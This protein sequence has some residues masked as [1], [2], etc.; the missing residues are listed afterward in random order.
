MN[1]EFCGYEYDEDCGKYGCP[2][3]NGEGLGEESETTPRKKAK[4]VDELLAEVRNRAP[5]YGALY[6]RKETS[7]DYMKGTY[8]KLYFDVP[9]HLSTAPA[10]DAWIRTQDE[11]RAAI[12]RKC[13]AYAEWKTAET[14]IK[15]ILTEA[16]VWRTKQATDRNLDKAHR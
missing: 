5:N 6:G 12:E 3:C 7:D 9:D 11:Y 1:C 16:E 8:A 14:Y 15:L 4:G 10:R 13:E 2:N